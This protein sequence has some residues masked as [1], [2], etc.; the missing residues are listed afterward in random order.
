MKTLDRPGAKDRYREVPYSPADRGGPRGPPCP[1]GP[2]GNVV[3][4][5]VPGEVLCLFPAFW[6]FPYKKH[7]QTCNNHHMHVEMAIMRQSLL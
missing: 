6:T 1:L 5:S 2:A 7:L 3:G 4:K